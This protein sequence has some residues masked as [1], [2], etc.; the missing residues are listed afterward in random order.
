MAEQVCAGVLAYEGD[1][2]IEDVGFYKDDALAVLTSGGTQQHKGRLTVL[3]SAALARQ[4]LPEAAPQVG[5]GQT[6]HS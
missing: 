1:S 6:P 5:P 3:P 2:E 4:C